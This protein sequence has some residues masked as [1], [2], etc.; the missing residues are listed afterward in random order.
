[1]KK[2]SEKFF[3]FTHKPNGVY[4]QKLYNTINRHFRAEFVL[5]NKPSDSRNSVYFVALNKNISSFLRLVKLSLGSVR[6]LRQGIKIVD[7]IDS[8]F[9]PTL[10]EKRIAV[11]FETPVHVE[12]QW[13][14]Y[15]KL[16]VKFMKFA[17][18]ILVKKAQLVV[19]I[20]EPM[21]NYCKERGARRIIVCPNYPTRSFRP[22]ESKEAW[23]SSNGLPIDSE[24]ALYVAGGR[25]LEIYGLELLLRAWSLVEKERP[26]ARLLI[27]GP[28]QVSWIKQYTE[29]L[30][31]KRF[32]VVGPASYS[33]LPNWVNTA[34]VCL[35]PRTPGFPTEFYNDEDSTKINEYAAL[36]KPIVAC[37]YLPSEQYF[38]TPQEPEEFAV[39]IIRAFDGQIKP[40]IPHYWE[41]NEPLLVEAIQK[42]LCH[43]R[44]EALSLIQV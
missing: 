21:G 37:G 2:Y 44:N 13:L 5:P 41:E 8:G 9:F 32:S 11:L 35:A 33:S 3:I 19:A 30:N 16:S 6:R 34:D 14:Q 25:M 40:A 22:T 42:K 7:T 4:E 31:I 23:M 36:A 17:Q 26:K 18:D 24:I 12:M 15:P 1:M 38:L 20:N 10:I 39:G 27:I 29:E 28:A 43:K